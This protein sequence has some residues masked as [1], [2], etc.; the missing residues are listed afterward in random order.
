MGNRSPIDV[1][2]IDARL[3]FNG[4]ASVATGDATLT[5]VVAPVAARPMLDLLATLAGR[6]YAR[7]RALDPA[8]RQDLRRSAT[9]HRPEWR[10]PRARAGR[11]RRGNGQVGDRQALSG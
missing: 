5:F 2:A 7:R 6:R 4:A 10:R 3:R 11:L 1:S 9:T 8:A